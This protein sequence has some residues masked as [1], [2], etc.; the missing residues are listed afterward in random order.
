MLDKAL[1]QALIYSL[2]LHLVLFGTFRIR[3][4]DYQELTP[5]MPP[6]NVAIDDVELVA[7]VEKTTSYDPE[8]LVACNFDD[9]EYKALHILQ[10]HK[11]VKMREYAPPYPTNELTAYSEKD[12]ID[13]TRSFTYAPK[14]YPL[15]LKLSSELK[16]L[17]LVEDGSCLF[18]EKGPNEDL[19]HLVLASNHFPIDYSVTISGLTGTVVHLERSKMFLDRELQSVADRIIKNIQFEPFS[20]KSQAGTITLIFCTTGEDIK[21]Y[22]HD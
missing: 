18:R 4:N 9:D 20:Q 19:S 21:K 10:T 11:P 16:G 15:Q 7:S 6:L 3:L 5:E 8:S 1:L 12:I 2:S 14:V 17:T 22:L 13:L